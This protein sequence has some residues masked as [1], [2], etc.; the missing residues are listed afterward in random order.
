MRARLVS[1]LIVLASFGG[2]SYAPAQTIVSNVLFVPWQNAIS[3]PMSNQVT[4][5]TPFDITVANDAGISLDPV[6]ATND[7]NGTAWF[8]NVP[9]GFYSIEMDT[10]AVVSPITINLT[11]LTGS[12]NAFHLLS[13]Y[14]NDPAFTS[15]YTRAQSDGRY[16][17]QFGANIIATTNNGQVTI[18]ATS[19]GGTNVANIIATNGLSGSTNGITIT[20]SGAGLQP[21]STTLSN[22]SSSGLINGLTQIS[23]VV[24]IAHLATGTPDGTKFIR[25]DGALATPPGS[26]SGTVTSISGDGTYTTGSVTTSGALTPITSPAIGVANF[27]G[28]LPR[29][30]LV[31][32]V[33]NGEAAGG[34]LTGT[35]PNPGISLLASDIPSLDAAKVTTGV[36]AI[37][38]LATGTPD[39]TKFVRDDGTLAAAGGTSTATVVAV[40]LS[41]TNAPINASL[42]ASGSSL[43]FRISLTANIL[44]QTPT[45]GTDG[46]RILFKLKQDSTGNRTVVFDTGYRFSADITSVTNGSGQFPLTLSTNASYIDY[47]GVK[48]DSTDSKWDVI[49]FTRGTH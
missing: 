21:A 27:T 7:I 40:T 4:T 37:A 38:R 32:A 19:S 3:R 5:L 30:T 18:S 29:A 34:K 23:N 48:F 33:T 49:S 25:D 47:V 12:L 20:I 36:F 39:G 16:P 9:P 10:I 24:P 35:F 42:G 13:V 15:A 43:E 22:F 6:S 41:G 46:Q 45:S 14:T 8:T 31:N 11:N 28:T 1:L 44:V 17:S 26:G 2:C